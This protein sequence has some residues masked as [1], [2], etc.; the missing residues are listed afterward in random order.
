MQ[1]QSQATQTRRDFVTRLSALSLTRLARPLAADRAVEDE[2]EAAARAWL[3]VVD[4]G[5][6]MQSWGEAAPAFKE[7]ITQEQWLQAL[8][9]ARSPLGYC[10]SRRCTTR[11]LVDAVPGV[12]KGPYVVIQFTTEFQKRASAI[13]T[14]TPALGTDGRWR[15]SGYFI[16]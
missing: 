1:M 10:V 13:E 8:G 11:R 16:K 6:Y 14:I 9:S 12:P 3:G 5:R 15:V 4:N 2:A 7:A